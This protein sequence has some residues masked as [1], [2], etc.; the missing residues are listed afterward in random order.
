MARVHPLD[1]TSVHLSQTPHD[2]DDADDE[3][4]ADAQNTNQIGR[5]ISNLVVTLGAGLETGLGDEFSR[6]LSTLST[7]SREASHLADPTRQWSQSEGQALEPATP[8][9]VVPHRQITQKHR[10]HYSALPASLK[11]LAHTFR[12]VPAPRDAAMIVAI[13]GACVTIQC[14][15]AA[16]AANERGPNSR[17]LHGLLSGVL[18]SFVVGVIFLVT[19]PTRVAGE[20]HRRYFV[21][22]PITIGVGV[23][24]GSIRI[25]D[26]HLSLLAMT[27]VAIVIG[28]VACLLCLTGDL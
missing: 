28:Y 5:N 14:V 10:D 18:A 4:D 13:F 17:S 2:A 12:S 6:S 8:R 21:A 11:E 9:N 22:F 26:T 16:Y 7:A 27:V 24:L 1:F 20:F 25:G 19:A 3:L 15:G 23:G